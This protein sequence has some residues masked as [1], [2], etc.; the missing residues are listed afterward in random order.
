[1]AKN[2]IIKWLQNS[3]RYAQQDK[4]KQ[5]CLESLSK[6]NGLL[7]QDYYCQKVLP[8]TFHE[9]QCKGQWNSF[10]KKGMMLHAVLLLKY[11]NQIHKHTYFTTAYRS[12]HKKLQI[13]LLSK[14][15]LQPKTAV[16]CKSDNADSYHG[17]CYAQS[18]FEK[19]KSNEIYLLHLHYN[20]PT[21]KSLFQW[22]WQND[23]VTQRKKDC[24]YW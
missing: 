9:G 24:W 1:M 10:H 2:N 12:D 13:H 21:H 15:F 7:I 23:N 22:V 5:D 18:L 19:C 16:L 6:K 20:K 4:A 3:I 11:N 14:W 17:N 8:M